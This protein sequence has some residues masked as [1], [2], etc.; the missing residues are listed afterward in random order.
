VVDA[1]ATKFKDR[2][3]SDTLLIAPLELADLLR[4]QKKHDEAER[5]YERV[6]DQ[7]VA[8]DESHPDKQIGASYAVAAYLGRV[9]LIKA[10]GKDKDEAIEELKAEARKRVPEA[11]GQFESELAMMQ[12]LVPAPGG[13]RAEGADEGATEQAGNKDEAPE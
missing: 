12:S 2:R 8:W 10:E 9:Q 4:E 13:R 7:G 3:A 11:A 1:D 5:M 6:I